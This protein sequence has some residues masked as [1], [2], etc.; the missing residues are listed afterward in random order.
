MQCVVLGHVPEEQLP[1]EALTETME[2]RGSPTLSPKR[3]ITAF[4]PTPAGSVEALK[5]K[6]RLARLRGERE[7]PVEKE[8]REIAAKE[9]AQRAEHEHQP[10]MCRLRYLVHLLGLSED[11]TSHPNF[12]TCSKAGWI[13]H[14]SLI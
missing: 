9:R 10:A 3:E 11:L 8:K 13:G 12:K 14:T 5:L 6:L 4:T 2:T 7:D 1:G